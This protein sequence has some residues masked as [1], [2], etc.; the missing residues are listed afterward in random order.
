MDANI[1]KQ[2][3]CNLNG[4]WVGSRAN[5]ASKGLQLG[6]GYPTPG[7]RAWRLL[8]SSWRSLQGLLGPNRAPRLELWKDF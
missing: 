7:F 1:D 3:V 2:I 4:L 6:V 5:I 8:G